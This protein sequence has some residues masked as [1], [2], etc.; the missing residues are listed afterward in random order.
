MERDIPAG[1]SDQ[2]RSVLLEFFK[3]HISAGQLTQRLGIETLPRTRNSRSERQSHLRQPPPDLPRDRATRGAELK[4]RPDAH[5]PRRS[6]ERAWL[7]ARCF[8][9]EPHATLVVALASQQCRCEPQPPARAPPHA[10][11]LGRAGDGAMNAVMEPARRPGAEGRRRAACDGVFGS[12]GRGRGAR[13]AGDP[14][15]WL[16]RLGRYEWLELVV[17]LSSEPLES[18]PEPP[19]WLLC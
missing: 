4:A 19:F 11:M 9:H 7:L 6:R 12:D 14:S 17:V 2:Q 15:S 13:Y 8:R 5:A 1:L 3:G 16:P 10:F 18:W